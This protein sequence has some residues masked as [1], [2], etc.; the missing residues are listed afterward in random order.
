MPAGTNWSVDT[1]DTHGGS[2]GA[3]KYV[4]PYSGSGQA[5]LG[6]VLDTPS[7]RADG[8]TFCFWYKAS[9]A[10]GNAQLFNQSGPATTWNSGS[11][12][13]NLTT[14]WTKLCWTMVVA[15]PVS[16]IQ[17]GI[18]MPGSSGAITGPTTIWIDDVT[19]DP[20]V[21]VP[22]C[23]ALI[24]GCENLTENGNWTTPDGRSTLALSTSNATQGTQSMDVNVTSASGW[25]KIAGLDNFSQTDWSSVSKMVLDMH[26]DSSVTTG[27]GY[28]QIAL[29]ADSSDSVLNSSSIYST[30]GNVT[31]GSVTVGIGIGG[32]PVTNL[33]RKLYFVLNEG[34][35]TTGHIYIDNIR[36]IYSPSCPTA[37]PTPV[38]GATWYFEGGTQ[39]SWVM[40]TGGTFVGTGISVG[41]PGINSTYCLDIAGTYTGGNQSVGAELGLGTPLN[42]TTYNGIRAKI[43]VDANVAGDYPCA[44]IQLGDGT[45]YPMS[46]CVNPAQGGWRQLDFPATLWGTFTKTNLNYIKIYVQSA[47]GGTWAAGHVKIDNVEFY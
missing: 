1:T 46:A 16:M 10:T 2:A 26:V 23:V 18:Q 47:S 36:L 32:G 5:L 27:S 13:N 39:E 44:F 9:S 11:W 41:T 33:L 45:N 14:T 19:L 20:P 35:G 8:T 25:N 28:C 22:T 37:T 29:Q 6:I 17:F 3:L 34:T 7:A 24:N 4:L 15:D 30:T 40:A 21:V 38:A 31:N 43:Y 12:Q 42:A